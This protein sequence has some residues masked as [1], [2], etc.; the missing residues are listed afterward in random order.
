VC[1]SRVD[2]LYVAKSDRVSSHVVL[3]AVA[4]MAGA[5]HTH[6]QGNPTLHA[7]KDVQ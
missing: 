4:A 7:V 6:T 1:S 5:G 3:E 2:P